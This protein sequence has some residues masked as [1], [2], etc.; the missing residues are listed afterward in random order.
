MFGRKAERKMFQET[1]EHQRELAREVRAEHEG[2]VNDLQTRIHDLEERNK[3][4]WEKLMA[5][6]LPEFAT[7]RTQTSEPLEDLKY[8]PFLEEENAGEILDALEPER[9]SQNEA[10]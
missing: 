4:L 3:D 9:N 7:Y 2:I 1:L 10:G 8:N 5:R 6:D